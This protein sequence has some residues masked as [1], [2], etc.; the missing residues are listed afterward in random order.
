MDFG[1]IFR[2]LGDRMTNW[3]ARNGIEI[4]YDIRAGD[5]RF[6]GGPNRNVPRRVNEPYEERQEPALH[7]G[8]RT[9]LRLG[10]ALGSAVIVGT[11]VA[12]AGVVLA[13]P[14]L[15]RSSQGSNELHSSDLL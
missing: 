5:M 7:E 12:A 9:L 11:A 1:S 4:H 3:L 8:T 15:M 10:A 6:Q 2:S 13:A 14:D